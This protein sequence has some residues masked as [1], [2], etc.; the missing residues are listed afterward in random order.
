RLP[1]AAIPEKHG[2]ATVLALGD[3]A[4]EAAVLHRVIL[5]VHRQPLVRGIEAR[6]LGDRPALENA[7]ELEPK[8]VVQARCGVLLNQAGAG[9][10]PADQRTGGTAREARP[11]RDPRAR[12]SS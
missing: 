2:A 12:A 8:I 7:F 9:R 4:L 5:D 6:S 10:R 11:P 1:G 3:D